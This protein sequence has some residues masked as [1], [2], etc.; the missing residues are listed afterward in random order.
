MTCPGAGEHNGSMKRL[1]PLV[2]AVL[3]L[4]PALHA[5]AQDL[6]KI[7]TKF[8]ETSIAVTPP[9]DIAT[10]AQMKDVVLLA[11]PRVTTKPGLKAKVEVGQDQAL[12]AG[13]VGAPDPARTGLSLET[14][15]VL[16]D[17]LSI[18]YRLRATKCDLVKSAAQL[19][20]TVETVSH[21]IYAAGSAKDG[22][23]VWLRIALPKTGRQVLVQVTFTRVRP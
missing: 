13:D 16:R 7:E 18:A 2:L 23:P 11:A 15:A 21:D 14:T 17:D 3:A 9:I 10:L 20:E 19:T 8:I 12:P 4:V 5:Q 6:I 1:L 22:E